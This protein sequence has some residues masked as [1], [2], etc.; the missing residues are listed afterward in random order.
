MVSRTRTILAT[1][2]MALALGALG[3]CSDD[4]KDTKVLGEVIERS[5][6]SASSSSS[7]GTPTTAG[8]AAPTTTA[9]ATTT[10]AA[11]APTTAAPSVTSPPATSPPRTSPAP[12]DPPTP[13][14]LPP[15]VIQV[16][17]DVPDGST[18]S[19][20][21]DGPSGQLSQPLD[22][23]VARFENLQEGLYEIVVSVDTNPPPT[24]GSGSTIGPAHSESRVKVEVRD[25]DT[26]T[27]TCSGY[28]DCDSTA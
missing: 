15:P 9:P 27:M 25:G 7:S 11:S 13:A 1:C 23:G 14:T 4:A 28:A 5:G 6:A 21:I 26:A 12:T 16:D 18:G 3:A 20:T 22:S 17:Y 8:P 24:D 2:A 19:A 10:T